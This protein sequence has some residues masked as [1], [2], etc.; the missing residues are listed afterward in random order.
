MKVYNFLSKIMKITYLKI[1]SNKFKT[2]TK[3]LL[4]KKKEK[5]NKREDKEKRKEEKGKERCLVK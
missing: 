1:L 3:N 2:F 5:E 4:E